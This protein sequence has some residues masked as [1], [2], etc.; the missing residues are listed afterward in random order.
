MRCRVEDGDPDAEDW[1]DSAGNALPP[2]RFWNAGLETLI[3]V[4]G[5]GDCKGI[6]LNIWERAKV[7]SFL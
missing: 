1:T 5:E 7:G 4:D 2:D 3:A 6:E